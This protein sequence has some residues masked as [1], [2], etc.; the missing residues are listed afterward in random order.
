MRRARSAKMALSVVAMAV[1]AVM[2]TLLCR[3]PRTGYATPQVT[4]LAPEPVTVHIDGWIKCTAV[5]LHPR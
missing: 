2:L 3:E 4:N 1:A 5:F